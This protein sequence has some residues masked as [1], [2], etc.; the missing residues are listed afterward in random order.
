VAKL[1]Q[2]FGQIDLRLPGSTHLATFLQRTS[3]PQPFF[4]CGIPGCRWVGKSMGNP[5]SP[6]NPNDCC[7][8]NKWDNP[9]PQKDLDPETRLIGIQIG[10]IQT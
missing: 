8:P 7:N 9:N 1:R 3:F 4:F 6:V 5:P 2:L 10:K